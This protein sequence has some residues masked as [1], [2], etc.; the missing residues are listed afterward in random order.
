MDYVGSQ[1]IDYVVAHFTQDGKELEPYL[2][3]QVVK[4]YDSRERE[5][6]GV[7][8]CQ[9]PHTYDQQETKTRNKI[10]YLNLMIQCGLFIDSSNYH[11]RL[12]QHKG[13]MFM[14]QSFNYTTSNFYT[15]NYSGILFFLHGKPMTF[16]P[17]NFPKFTRRNNLLAC[18][19]FINI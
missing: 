9:K 8:K 17:F 5:V 18:K 19:C 2:T 4:V 3:T 1:S 14:S 15:F 16:S 11:F 13:N 12:K 6:L 7:K 10:H